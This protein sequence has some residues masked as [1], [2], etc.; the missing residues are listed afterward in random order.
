MIDFT[1]SLYL[2]MTHGSAE[3][4]SWQQLTMGVPAVLSEPYLAKVIAQQIAEMQG[5]E[6]GIVAPSTLHLYWDLFGYLRELPIAIFIDEHIYPVSRYGIERLQKGSVPVRTFTH[7]NAA[8]L[9]EMIKKTIAKGLVPYVLTD[10]F[11]PFCGVAAPIEKYLTI[12]K[13]FKGRIIVDDT[14]AFG[15]LGTLKNNTTPYG[16]GGGGSLKWKGINDN[17]IITIVSLAKAFGVP[18][19]VL[20]GELRFINAFKDKSETRV[21]SSPTSNAHLVAASHAIRLNRLQGDQRR[22]KLWHNVQCIKRQ[23]RKRGIFLQGGIFPVQH[24]KLNP[25]KTF[26]LFKRLKRN[27]IKTAMIIPHKGQQPAVSFI[28]RCNHSIEEIL[29]LGDCISKPERIYQFN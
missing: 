19:S 28:I 12:I 13:P 1:S 14:Q 20:S 7:F 24:T 9:E 17:S 11:C 26:E 5:L 18:M 15:I 27:D 2:A 4:N 23:L 6:S 3:L 22:S 8:S 29:R 10:G 21:N 25:H 16:S